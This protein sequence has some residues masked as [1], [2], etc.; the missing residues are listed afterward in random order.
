MVLTIISHTPHYQKEEDIYSWGPT[1]RELNF[2]TK[3][4]TEIYH[5]APLHKGNVTNVYKRYESNRIKFIALKPTGG[6]N[7]IS[8]I[9]VVLKI[10]FN[11]TL[12]HRY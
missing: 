7:L 5:I 4:F 3:I 2:L 1:S 8:K 9:D 11:L 10:P 6:S 12:I